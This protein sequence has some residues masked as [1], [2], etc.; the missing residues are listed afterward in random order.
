[1]HPRQKAAEAGEAFYDGNPCRTCSNTKRHTINASCVQCS[2]EH[3]KRSVARRR[4][5]IKELLAQARAG[6]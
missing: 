5:E 4:Q 3:A 1:M 6:A 2:N